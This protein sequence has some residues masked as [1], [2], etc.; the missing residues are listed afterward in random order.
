VLTVGKLP[1]VPDLLAIDIPGGPD[2]V[3][4]LRRVWD[5]GDAALPVDQRLSE[6]AKKALFDELRPASVL[7]PLGKVSTLSGGLA[8][9]RG[10]ALVM[11]TSGTTGKPKGVVLTHDAVLASAKATSERLGVQ[12]ERHSWLACLPL[13]HVG[14][15]SVVTRSLLTDTPCIVL[16]GFDAE[17]VLANSGPDVLVSLV[18]TALRRVEASRFRTVVLGG[19]SPPQDLPENVV[20]TYGLTETGSGVV[21]DGVPLDGVEIG[22]ESSTSEILVRGPMLLRAYRDG[23]SPLLPGGWLA[24]RDCGHVDDRHRLHVDGRIDDLIVTGGENVWPDPV[25]AAIRTHPLVAEVAVGSRPDAEWGQRVVAWVVP[26]DGDHPPALGE[27]RDL[28]SRLVAPFAAPRELVI[29]K[30]LPRT[31]IGKVR[32]GDLD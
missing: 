8:V 5:A 17:T 2:F 7:L 4:A 22:V 23:S 18:P 24:T 30:R 13:N 11:A 27:L 29:A 14:G 28:V 3:D 6:G 16:S 10:D 1:A 21:Y 12:A 15:M 31:S 32:R 26:G 25:E 9:E 19:S 20:T